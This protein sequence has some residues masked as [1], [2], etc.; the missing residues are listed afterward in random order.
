MRR[1]VNLHEHPLCQIFRLRQIPQRAIDKIHH[2]QAV[3]RDQFLE[4]LAVPELDPI[5]QRRVFQFRHRHWDY[6]IVHDVGHKAIAVRP[7]NPETVGVRQRCHAPLNT[8]KPRRLLAS[9]KN[10]R[11]PSPPVQDLLKK[12]KKSAKERLVLPVGRS[13]A[14]ELKRYKNFLKVETARLKMS[15]K[16]APA[17]W[18]FAWTRGYSTNCTPTSSKPS[19]GTSNRRIPIP[20][21]DTL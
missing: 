11:L 13:P 18:R 5:H 2:R 20:I 6:L 3:A 17:D 14:R 16:A 10:F 12:I 7:F 19:N 21:P 1:L 15:M 9:E 4:G 8:K